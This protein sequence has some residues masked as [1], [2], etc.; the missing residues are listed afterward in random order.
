MAR[1]PFAKSGWRAIVRPA[2]PSARRLRSKRPP[3]HEEWSEQIKLAAL[4]DRWLDPSCSF[5]T[6]TDPVAASATS[7]RGRRRRGVKPG[8]PDVIVWYCGRTTAVELKSR[9][10]GCNPAQRMVRERLLRAGVEW[11]ECRSANSAMWALAD[12]G[13]KFREIANE[14]GA[15]ERWQ[16]PELADWESPRSDPTEPR[17]NAPEVLAQRRAAVQRWR[18]RQRNNA[19][20]QQSA[21]M[22]D[23]IHRRRQAATALAE[24]KTRH[25]NV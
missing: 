23:F 19:P 5:W 18:E 12:S 10:G 17:P 22:G 11:W 24:R 7:G 15:M 4:L 20:R 3:R 25:D 6:A 16:Q 9:A 1:H 14:D 2:S 13:V 8:I 21:P